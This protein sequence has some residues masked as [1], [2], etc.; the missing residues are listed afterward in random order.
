[1]IDHS[2][3]TRVDGA[4][5]IAAYRAVL[6]RGSKSFDFASRF[7]PADRR[8]D[9]AIVYTF[10]R[11]VDDIADE[12][13]D[14][15]LAREDLLRLQRELGGTDEPRPLVRE[16]QAVGARRNMDLRPAV[17]LIDGALS[18]LESVRIGDDRGLLRYC[19]R[20]AGTVGLMMCG[21]LGVRPSRLAVAS[22]FAVD[23]GIAMQLTNIVRDVKEDAARGRVYLPRSRL[24]ACGVEPE[25]LLR[26]PVSDSVRAATRR[27]VADLVAMADTYYDSARRG[28]RYIPIR[29]RLAIVV[30]SR[31]YREIGVQL[32]EHGGDPWVGRT[33]VSTGRKLRVALGGVAMAHSLP[34]LGWWPR[35]RHR[36]ELHSALDGLP[37]TTPVALLPGAEPLRS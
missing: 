30:A 17:H 27:V 21:V 11:T 5:S 32:M 6:A 34:V 8:D 22:P 1:V 23:L 35:P 12:T 16:L 18:D 24:R 25:M 3:S 29:A 20:V 19:Y 36:P 37:G 28:M 14:T 31:V 33:V 9:A 4:G 26:H 7:L 2:P 13:P 10:C 15:S